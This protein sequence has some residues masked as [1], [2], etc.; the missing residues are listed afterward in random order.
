VTRSAGSR[1]DFRSHNLVN[2]A[3]A[4]G[5][6]VRPAACEGCGRSPTD[7]Q[8][9]GAQIEAHHDDYNKPFEVRW[10]CKSC[11]TSWHRRY[12]AIAARPDL[13][14]EPFEAMLRTRPVKKVDEVDRLLASLDEDYPL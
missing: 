1:H 4:A 11:H 9:G 3:I 6:I 8:D 7:R 2:R 5:L 14:L 10:L 13:D 12:V